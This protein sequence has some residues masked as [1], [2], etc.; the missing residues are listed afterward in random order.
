M[1]VCVF[2]CVCRS[3]DAFRQS[4]MV[5][6]EHTGLSKLSVMMQYCIN[7][8]QCRRALIADSFGEKWREEDCPG[9]CDVCVKLRNTA[10]DLPPPAKQTSYQVNCNRK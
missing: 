6:T 9:A 10:A 7:E 2:V 1:C 8:V 3:A 5:F 4:A